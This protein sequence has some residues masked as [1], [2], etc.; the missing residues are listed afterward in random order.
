VGQDQGFNDLLSKQEATNKPNVPAPI[1]YIRSEIGPGL[2]TVETALVTHTKITIFDSFKNP[3]FRLFWFGSMGQMAAMNMQMMSRTWYAYELSGSATMLGLIALSLALPMLIFSLYGG[4]IADRAQKRYVLLAGQSASG[5]LALGIAIS[6]TIGSITVT[7]LI[8]AGIIQGT[9]MGLMMPSRQAIIP[10][11]VGEKGLMN[12]I[13]LNAAGMNMNRLIAPGLAGFLIGWLG[14]QGVYYAMAALYLIAICFIF[15][16]KPTFSTFAETK[17]NWEDLKEGVHY[18]RSNSTVLGL[19]LLTLL[20]VLLSVPFQFLLPIFTEDILHVGPEGLGILFSMSGVG[21]LV[22]SLIIASLDNANRGRLFLLSGLILAIS[23]IA[24][25]ISTWYLV[26]LLIIL[27]IGLGNAG[28]MA[29][30]NTLVQSYTDDIHRGR[31]MSIY[32]MEFGLMSLSTFAVS[33][34]SEF[35]GIQ[36]SIGGAAAI[37]LIISVYYLK[38]VPS[39]RNLQ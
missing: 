32:M 17:S 1:E 31:V 7:H 20:M 14:I 19:L 34:I 12:A 11:I 39:I 4:I 3:Q 23:L 8:V 26:S 24:F 28:R 5:I 2:G 37:L 30:S 35:V 15:A 9:I 10:E 21:A 18:I 27:P 36:W 38:F 13:S 22:G 25:S 16:L 29:I 33:I 6:I